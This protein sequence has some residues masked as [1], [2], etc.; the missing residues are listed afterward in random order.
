MILELSLESIFAVF[1]I[2]FV[3][4][5]PNADIAIATVGLTEAVIS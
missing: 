4:H 2:Y 3:G 1:D 5:L